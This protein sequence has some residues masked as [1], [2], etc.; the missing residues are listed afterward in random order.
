M[1]SQIIHVDMDANFASVEE[2][3]NPDLIGKP[4]VVGG[5]VGSRGVVAAA[6]YEARKFGIHSAMPMATAV[7][8]CPCIAS[9]EI[10]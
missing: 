2:L 9:D 10:G 1:T 5:A 6:S 4:V 8:L 3:D 7:K